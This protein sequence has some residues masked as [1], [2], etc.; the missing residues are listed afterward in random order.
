MNVGTKRKHVKHIRVADNY[1]EYVV[2]YLVDYF[3]FDPNTEQHIVRSTSCYSES[4]SSLRS[5]NIC[6]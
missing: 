2:E 4:G 1:F 6:L 5:F 3:E